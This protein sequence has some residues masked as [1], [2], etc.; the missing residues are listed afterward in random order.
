[1]AAKDTIWARFSE[2][3][4]EIGFSERGEQPADVDILFDINMINGMAA[5][6]IRQSIAH[7]VDG[8][9]E[10]WQQ[11]ACFTMQSGGRDDIPF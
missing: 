6:N 9:I 2:D 1:M 3:R 4:I 7:Q 10:E 8:L 5:N 11:E